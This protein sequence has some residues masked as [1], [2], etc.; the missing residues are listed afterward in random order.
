M[1]K[2][3]KMS[4]IIILSFLL[5]VGCSTL[6]KEEEIMVKGINFSFE[7]D[8]YL[9]DII[10]YDFSKKEESYTSYEFKGSDFNKCFIEAINKY[11]LNLSICDYIFIEDT[12]LSENKVNEVL[13]AI[14][15]FSVN[16][17]VSLLCANDITKDNFIDIKEKNSKITPFYTV[18]FLKDEMNII[19]PFLNEDLYVNSALLLNNDGVIS[20]L[21]NEELNLALT[22][23]AGNNN[24]NYN[25]ENSNLSADIKNSFSSFHMSDN[26]LFINVYFDIL[27]RNGAL[28]NEVA[29]DAFDIKFIYD[30]KDK[31][32]DLYNDQVVRSLLN[33]SWVEE[34]YN[35]EIKDIQVKIIIL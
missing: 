20:S 28:K 5:L 33:L 3:I 29:Q 10:A 16:I 13:M 24:F 15:E 27:S 14:D 6:A 35:M 19:L 31:I 34:Q 21:A 25:F 8:E 9:L 12:I 17:D 23:L 30:V 2:K 11:N 26:T 32:Y 1:I 18:N 22:L 4:L 7:G